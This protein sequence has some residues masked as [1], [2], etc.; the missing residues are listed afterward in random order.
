MKADQNMGQ[1]RLML[2]PASETAP[3]H[4]KFLAT[5]LVMHLNW[6]EKIELRELGPPSCQY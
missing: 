1:D 6:L 5:R 3:L 4:C 2:F